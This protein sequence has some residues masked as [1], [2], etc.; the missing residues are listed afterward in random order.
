ML[1][2]HDLYANELEELKSMSLMYVNGL[3]SLINERGMQINRR[4]AVY[5]DSRKPLVQV[6]FNYAYT[7]KFQTILERSGNPKSK[8]AVILL[9]KA[10]GTTD[11]S[12][13][14]EKILYCAECFHIK[15]SRGG[16]TTGIA[17]RIGH[18]CKNAMKKAIDLHS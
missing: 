2:S 14:K 18:V 8:E 3:L 15:K 6:Q 1:I 11:L 5:L 12:E 16:K 13:L 4:I 17:S 7:A 9:Q 10:F